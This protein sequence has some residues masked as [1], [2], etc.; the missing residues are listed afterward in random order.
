[1]RTFVQDRA[2]SGGGVEGYPLDRL[3]REIAYIAYYFHWPY[4]DVLALDHHERARLIDE[5]GG[6]NR[7]V[8]GEKEPENVFDLSQYG[9]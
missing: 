1:M 2:I 7:A 9:L 5:I 4:D 6:I 3:Y 8:S